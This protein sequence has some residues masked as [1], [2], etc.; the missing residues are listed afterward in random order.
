MNERFRF[1]NP[2]SSTIKAYGDAPYD[3]QHEQE[4]TAGDNGDQP[5]AV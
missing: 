4:S 2:S 3:Q 1:V 5:T